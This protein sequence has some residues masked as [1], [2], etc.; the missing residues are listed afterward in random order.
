MK[1]GG[2]VL[3]TPTSYDGD[4]TIM[5]ANI[6]QVGLTP[7]ATTFGKS[8]HAFPMGFSLITFNHQLLISSLENYLKKVITSVER[9][10]T[11][12]TS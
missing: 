12:V 6:P 5:L 1:S 11:K 2:R 10:K 9:R 4:G 3:M 8:V 7:Q